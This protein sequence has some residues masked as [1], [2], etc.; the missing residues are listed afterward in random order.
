MAK[1]FAEP[2]FERLRKSGGVIPQKKRSVKRMMWD[3][4]VSC[5]VASCFSS[6]PEALQTQKKKKKKQKKKMVVPTP[7]EG[8]VPLPN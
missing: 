1:E 3:C 4:A 7:A 6:P 5:L 2:E 8:I